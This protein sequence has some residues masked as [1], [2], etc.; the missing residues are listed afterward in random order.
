MNEASGKVLG[1]AVS[2]RTNVDGGAKDT[3]QKPVSEKW[4]S[5]WSNRPEFVDQLAKGTPGVHWR[6]AGTEAIV[7]D[8]LTDEGLAKWN[9]WLAKTFPE[10]SPEYFVE[11][12]PEPYIVGGKLIQYALFR[13]IE[14]RRL[15]KSRPSAEQRSITDED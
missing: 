2:I 14:Y 10:G 15:L 3:E 1:H 7:A 13:R 11:S 12:R 9:T 8:L 6:Y 4:A 5:D